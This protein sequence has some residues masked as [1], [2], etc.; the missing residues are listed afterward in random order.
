MTLAHTYEKKK[1]L[2]QSIFD[3]IEKIR[4]ILYSKHINEQKKENK[5]IN[6]QAHTLNIC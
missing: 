4:V 5:L 6:F 3:K 2:T 1:H